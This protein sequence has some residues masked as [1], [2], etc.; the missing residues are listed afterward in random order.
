MN[1]IAIL[2]YEFDNKQAQGWRESRKDGK[3]EAKEETFR[4]C[5]ESLRED[6]DYILLS[7]K[8]TK[9]KT[10][11]VEFEYDSPFI[12]KFLSAKKYIE[13]N[14]QYEWI[15]LVDSTD[16]I[17]LS[18]PEMK[19]DTL[20]L[21]IER[22]A[23][24]VKRYLQVRDFVLPSQYNP[25][26]P[27][28]ELTPE[29]TNYLKDR[30]L[31]ESVLD[32]AIICGH[33]DIMLKFLTRFEEEVKKNPKMI[34]EFILLNYILRKDFYPYINLSNI[35]PAKEKDSSLWWCHDYKLKA[36]N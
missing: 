17:M 35:N 15:S 31:Y 30:C 14:P 36:C 10:K 4:T 5:I 6:W 25:F 20:Y 1:K 23:E 28:L 32:I 18:S 21:G 7:N 29:A 16:S 34:V 3:Q 8:E 13:E 22:Y 26:T 24:D 27:Y 33:R 19:K 11:V 9:W 2:H 12:N